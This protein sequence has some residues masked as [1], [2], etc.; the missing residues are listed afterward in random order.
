[1][2]PDDTKDTDNREDQD[3]EQIPEQLRAALR[4]R[5]GGIRSL[6]EDIDARILT[7]TL[8][9]LNSPSP[10]PQKQKGLQKE[11][12]RWRWIVASVTTAAAAMMVMVVIQR[13]QTDDAAGLLA[14]RT[15]SRSTVSEQQAKSGYQGRAEVAS[16]NSTSFGVSQGKSNDI[17]NDGRVDI[18]DAFAMARRI[19]RGEAEPAWDHNQDG[20]VDQRDVDNLAQL[21]VTL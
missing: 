15:L 13:N 5:Y 11:R 10:D 18:L 17:D 9:L 4:Q 8:S 2:R 6:S 14:R 7:R 20:Q 19:K 1:M 16:A 3:E 21:T 12:R